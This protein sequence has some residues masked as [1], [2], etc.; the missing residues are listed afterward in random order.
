MTDRYN[1]MAVHYGERPQAMFEY[2]THEEASRL[3][4]QQAEILKGYAKRTATVDGVFIVIGEDEQGDYYRTQIYVERAKERL[5]RVVWSNVWNW[6][7]S[8]GQ[9][10][11]IH[12]TSDDGLTGKT[13]CGKEYPPHICRFSSEPRVGARGE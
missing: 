10:S 1:V 3:L 2:K 4:L 11:R 9:G 7:H 8:E 12:L 13:L 5:R 6:T